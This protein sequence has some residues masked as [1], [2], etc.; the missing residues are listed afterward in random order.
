MF[1]RSREQSRGGQP[2]DLG[3]SNEDVLTDKASNLTFVK[4]HG[5]GRSQWAVPK[6]ILHRPSYINGKS[7]RYTFFYKN[8]V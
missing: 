8:Q 4:N 6:I 1:R 3:A 7:L 2:Y 5:A